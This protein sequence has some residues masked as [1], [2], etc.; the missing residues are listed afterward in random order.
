MFEHMGDGI[1]KGDRKSLPITTWEMQVAEN[2]GISHLT[3]IDYN[4]AVPDH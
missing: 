3:L 1:G 4:L 2:S